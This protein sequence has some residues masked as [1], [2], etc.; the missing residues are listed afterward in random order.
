LT[1]DGAELYLATVFDIDYADGLGRADTALYVF[2]ANGALILIGGDSNVADDQRAPGNTSNADLSRGSAGTGDPFIGSA[3][4]PEGTYYVAV[5]NQQRGPA[6][7]DQFTNRDSLNPLLR[8]EPIDS[9]QRIAEERFEGDDFFPGTFGGPQIP[10]LFD[11]ESI[12]EYSLD[13]VLV[14]ANTSSA[15][16]LLNPFTGATYGTVG[17]FGDEINDV[18][19]TA[20]GELF[21]YTG[22]QGG[23]T[24]DAA[25]A[26]QRI[27]TAD[28]E[29][30]EVGLSGITTFHSDEIET[31]TLDDVVVR[32]PNQ[33]LE[34]AS[35]D[36]LDVEA[37]SIRTFGGNANQGFLVGNRPGNRV[38]NGVNNAG[39]L[40]YDDNILYS[41]NTATGEILGPTFNGQFQFLGNAN[42][43]LTAPITPVNSGAGTGPREIG[44]IDTDLPPS[45]FTQLGLS[46]ATIVNSAGRSV[47]TLFDG[48]AF[49]VTDGT[50][51]VTFELNQG[52]TLFVQDPA[53]IVDGQALT[54]TLPGEVPET[55]VF[56]TNPASVGS[57]NTALTFDRAA[58]P[59]TFTQSIAEQLVANGIPVSAAGNQLALPEATTVT[60]TTSGVALDEG[61]FLVGDDDVTFGN[62][63][64][65]LLPTDTGAVLAQR[66]AAA[67]NTVSA[68]PDLNA[69]VVATAQGGSVRIV[70]AQVGAFLDSTQA[71]GTTL[72]TLLNAGVVNSSA[73]TS[74][75]FGLGGTITGIEIV[76]G[77][78]FAISDQGVLY[79]VSGGSLNSS[80]QGNVGTVVAT[81][82]QLRGI[83]FSGLRAG[84]NSVDGGRYSDLLF[85]T[86]FGGDIYAFNT[87]GELQPIFA[88]GRTSISTGITGLNG[89]DFSTL[90]YNLWHV[91]NSR[92][93]DAGHGQNTQ[94]SRTRFGFTGGNSL[95]FNYE[96]NAFNGNYGPG[97]QP[98]QPEV[99]GG[100][101]TD[102]LD[103]Q[104]VRD[105]YN[106]PG[107]AKGTVQSNEF[108]LEGYA[109]AD[110]PTLYF[111]YFLETD[112]V[113][114][115]DLDV[116][117]T[118]EDQDSLRVY[119][120]DSNGVEHLVATNNEALDDVP[121]GTLILDEFDDPS[122]D[123]ENYNDAI[124]V[125]VQQ[126]FDNTG[127]WRQARVPLGEFAGQSGL[128]IRI[129]FSTAG[130]TF[131]GTPELRAVAAGTL[132]ENDAVIIN[133]QRFA[134][135]F[136]ETI[137]F[138][139]GSELAA[140]YDVAPNSPATFTLDGQQFAITDGRPLLADPNR[141]DI[142]VLDG[143]P[144]GT[145]LADLSASEIAQIVRDYFDTSIELTRLVPSGTELQL[146]YEMT[147]PVPVE[148]FLSGTNFVL[149]DGQFIDGDNPNIDDDDVLI[150]VV[151]IHNALNPDDEPK[152]LVE[153]TEDDIAAVLASQLGQVETAVTFEQLVPSNIAFATLYADSAALFTV[154]IDDVEYAFDDL[155]TSP[156]RN[157]T[158]EM[159]AVTVTDPARSDLAA[160]LE[161]AVNN[162]IGRPTP[163]F[164][165]TDGLSFDDPVGSSNDVLH[166]AT[167]LPYAGGNAVLNGSGILG[168]TDRLDVDL[169]SLPNVAAGSTVEVSVS[170]GN[171]GI[172]N[173]A[174]FFDQFGEEL[175]N[176]FR[177]NP[178]TGGPQDTVVFTV[179]VP[180]T[181]RLFIGFS[182]PENT[183][184]DPRIVGSGAI[185]QVGAYTASIAITPEMRIE[186]GDNEIEFFGA[187]EVTFAPGFG[188]GFGSQTALDSSGNP[189]AI[190]GTP[191]PIS[192]FDD[193]VEV[194]ASLREVI[195]NQFFRG[196]QELVPQSGSLLRIATLTVDDAG[197]YTLIDSNIEADRYGDIFGAGFVDGADDNE[198]NGAYIDD[199]II[200]F[201]E[202]GETVTAANAIGVNETFTLNPFLENTNPIPDDD[203][204]TSGAYNLEIRDGSE[205]VASGLV[206]DGGTASDARFRV[207]DTN[208]RLDPG[209]TLTTLPAAGIINGATFTIADANTRL[210]FEF[211]I[212]NVRAGAVADGANPILIRID[213]DATASEVANEIIRQINSSPVQAVLNATAARSN[214]TIVPG[215]T[216]SNDPFADNRINIYGDISF[217][218][219]VQ[220]R[221][222]F[223]EVDQ[224]DLRGD[225][226]RDREQQGVIL[227]ENNRFL[228]SQQSGVR[229]SRENQQRVAGPDVFDETPAVLS[230][231]RNLV[232][233]NSENLIPGA[234]I[235]NNVMAFNADSG[236]TISGL[237]GGGIASENPVGFDRIINNTIIGGTIQSGPELGS[238]VFAS[239]LFEEGGVSF[240]DAVV[241]STLALGDDVN[242]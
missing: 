196:D 184:Y 137:S 221:D 74:G 224:A 69:S 218:D 91:T 126:L 24:G 222:T 225:S 167:S 181:G 110:Q 242:Q 104:I 119:I 11:D 84:P 70:D 48:D 100:P 15:L 29:L 85:G 109:A 183:S 226:N 60:L 187:G 43:D 208:D 122:T 180:Q 107:G 148:V 191:V 39:L 232:E 94:F 36:G 115:D 152:T 163:I 209:A 79:S 125:E 161:E 12:I 86:T 89:L 166:L 228:F 118:G 88:G 179:T 136:A 128:G 95:A 38:F 71:A 87:A 72:N 216:A 135:D 202:R 82:T 176:V 227:V 64:I 68:T 214:G 124:D 213:G 230:Y 99:P 80:T 1:R 177:Q 154:T 139:S 190:N 134:I 168:P 194:A 235:R 229:I 3:E 102:R 111:N 116:G 97:E 158:P 26:Y 10:V 18:A 57:G 54:V 52:F 114:S 175:P 234:T 77:N 6:N 205:Y 103:G 206:P 4:L 98:A 13:D 197:P 219:D 51:S 53:V 144:T 215:R 92:S 42:P 178:I 138:P 21:A 106:L 132:A 188:F 204:S 65:T 212:D 27:N 2:D 143:Q 23:E 146:A 231:P 7:L 217:Q 145:T 233:L 81:A 207:F 185:A 189:V 162:Q 211:V 210:Q 203:S 14:Y 101:A 45:G 20:N 141:I 155:A 198:H 90:D 123:I 25:F 133:G 149:G 16:V 199:V 112:G 35:D 28:A 40:Q 220:N 169:V 165:T 30:T 182:G 157:I 41:F 96:T 113:D 33:T 236:I 59:E 164:A 93:G 105:T 195:A 32:D 61:L 131:T 34:V 73:L 170:S 192:Q 173:N 240:A 238:Q 142:N 46:D 120:I 49:T 31:I 19:F 223:A 193:A 56:T 47:A 153:L 127:S 201:A 22:L 58:T 121:D 159:V 186:N 156:P 160:L 66:I 108:S 171:F 150:D 130:T 5:S 151:A 78:L 63:P 129:E 147:D 140:L 237:D 50:N 76:G 37:I 44:Q 83:N 241:Q 55:F 239:I 174:R 200:G 75:G 17:Q 62:R 67:I 8:L 9:I 117:I 172:L